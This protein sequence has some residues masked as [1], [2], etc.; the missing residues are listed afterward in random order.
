MF[1]HWVVLSPYAA[2]CS[3]RGNALSIPRGGTRA[4]FQHR[5]PKNV[6]C[7]PS[8]RPN[9]N[10]CRKAV[11]K[12]TELK[13][14]CFFFWR[15]LRSLKS[16]ASCL[17]RIVTESHQKSSIRRVVLLRC[18]LSHVG[19]WI[20]FFMVGSLRGVFVWTFEKEVAV[21]TTFW[22]SRNK[23]QF[24]AP[25]A[26]LCCCETERFVASFQLVSAFSEAIAIC[27]RFNSNSLRI[28]AE[29]QQSQSNI[30]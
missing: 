28:F 17:H 26:L 9:T 29:T 22:R 14:A 15:Q 7:S 6:S 16:G 20:Y 19:F 5:T 18:F 21:R 30:Y 10:I 23:G 13:K 12:T 25:M 8:W 11:V 3:V 2:T 24:I 4:F 1:P 27:A